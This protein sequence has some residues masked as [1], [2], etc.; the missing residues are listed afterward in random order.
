MRVRFFSI[1]FGLFAGYTVGTE[2]RVQAQIR[3]STGTNWPQ[4]LS[5]EE[6]PQSQPLTPAY[7]GRPHKPFDDV[8]LNL[9]LT[10]DLLYGWGANS[11]YYH[12]GNTPSAAGG[13]P[14][15][16]LDQPP[17]YY[18]QPAPNYYSAPPPGAWSQS[19]YITPNTAPGV[20]SGKNPP[21]AASEANNLPAQSSPSQNSLRREPQRPATTAA[22]PERAPQRRK[23]ILVRPESA[24]TLRRD[25]AV[26]SPGRPDYE[27][28]LAA[29]AAGDYQS[30]A[31]AASNAVAADSGNG[32]LQLYLAQ[33]QFAVGDFAA[34]A[35]SL[36][37]AFELLPQSQWGLVIE[38]FRQF[39]KQNDYVP[40]VEKLLA[41]SEQPETSPLGHALQAY[42]Y[43]YLGHPDA[44]ADQLR[45]A[46]RNSDP[47]R[48]AIELKKLLGSGPTASE[49]ALPSPLTV[50]E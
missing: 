1:A 46:L 19:Q 40:Q 45:A 49:E 43:H 22:T 48:L 12:G 44:A 10:P 18:G 26:D 34:S 3:L 38:N 41:F 31:E 9:V 25:L 5:Q 2:S 14:Q 36:T 23:S 21:L 7:R 4:S 35:D 27:I 32:K 28:S 13:Y 42:H 30:A 47:P 11:G 16:V 6:A 8:N 17:F 24:P 15:P 37:T 33:C 29:F 50:N 20:S 39:Y